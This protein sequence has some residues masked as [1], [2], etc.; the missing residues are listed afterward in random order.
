M[1]EVFDYHLE[2]ERV[3]YIMATFHG[4]IKEN[5]IGR[6]IK[7]I[8]INHWTNTEK[9]FVG[10]VEDSEEDCLYIRLENSELFCGLMKDLEDADARIEWLS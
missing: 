3:F 6:E 5:C 10:T 4:F 2:K 8:N 7:W 1:K 9:E